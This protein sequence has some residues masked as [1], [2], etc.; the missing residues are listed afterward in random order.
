[1]SHS[2]RDSRQAVAVKAWL[3][4]HEPGL[5][6]EIF[7]DLDPHTDIRPGE[8][9]R[10]ALQQANARCE[11]VICLLSKHWE[12][13]HECQT[14][15]R[16]AENL[17]KTILCARLEPV[18]DTNIT[19]EW[20]R[21]D[22]FPDHGPTTDVDVA[23]GAAPVVLDTV[24]LQRLLEALR[25]LGIGAK[26]FPWPPPRD[27]D[28]AQYRGWAPLDE[29]DAAV[30]FGRGAQILGGLDVLH[31][32]RTSGGQVLL[33][34]SGP[35]GAGNSSFLR[36]GLLPRLRRDDGRFLPLP[37]VRPE[38]AVL[39]GERGLANAIHKLRTGLGLA[40]PMLGEIKNACHPQHVEGLRGWLAEA[41]QV[42]RTRLLD[43]AAELPATTILVLPV[44]QV[45]EPGLQDER[46]RGNGRHHLRDTRNRPD[47]P[48]PLSGRYRRER[49]SP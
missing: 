2:S 17:G 24:G 7:L 6:E 11:A 3:I 48:V 38:R 22:L 23:D 5:A 30:F 27:P 9:W 44:D 12:A 42:A 39:S 4:E 43:V 49:L 29:A 16:Y 34:H 28:R 32:M 14:E 21:C 40:E 31:R 36:A 25:T 18:P 20:Q 33:R 37:I 13:S 35:V 26:H 47:H 46:Q 8:R 41:G 45:E 1:M 15:F 19:S 10:Q